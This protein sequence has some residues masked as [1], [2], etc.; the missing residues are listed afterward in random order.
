MLGVSSARGLS[1][2]RV[3]M[4]DE[5]AAS[6]MCPLSSSSPPSFVLAR[7]Y[8]EAESQLEVGLGAHPLRGEVDAS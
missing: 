4:A 2:T 3:G 8:G 6:G 1:G 7:G 5:L